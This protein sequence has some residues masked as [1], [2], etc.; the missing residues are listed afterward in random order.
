MKN[1]AVFCSANDIEEKYTKPALE[2]A[3]LMAINKYH[4]VWGGGNTGL[5]NAIASVAKVN[6]SNLIGVSVTMLEGNIHRDADEIII[7]K[8]LG[9][10][11]A[12]MLEKSDAIVALVGGIGTL[13][14]I[15]EIIELKKQKYFG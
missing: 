15:T 9:E 13:D 8:T 14:E 3:R 5:M 12:T 10:R 11:K 6:G 7:T 4:L 1:I 2:F